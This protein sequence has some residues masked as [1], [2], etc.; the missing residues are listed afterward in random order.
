M[1]VLTEFENMENFFSPYARNIFSPI[2]WIVPL[3]S[4]YSELI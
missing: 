1:V 2:P 3:A 4:L